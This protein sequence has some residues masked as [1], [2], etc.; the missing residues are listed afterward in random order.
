L[1]RGFESYKAE[2]S[3]GARRNLAVW[4]VNKGFSAKIYDK[5]VQSAFLQKIVGKLGHMR[6]A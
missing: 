1:A 6:V 4:A 3:T 5:V 2:W